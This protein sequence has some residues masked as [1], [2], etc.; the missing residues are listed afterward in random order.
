MATL[1]IPITDHNTEGVCTQQYSVSYK[2]DGASEILWTGVF[3][4]SPIVLDNLGDDES[5]EV[6][7]TRLCCNGSV[8]TPTVFVVS[9]VILVAPTGFTAVQAGAN[10]NLDSDDYTGA[11]AYE[12]QRA[13]DVDFTVNL[14]DIASVAVSNATDLAVPASTYW[15]RWRAIKG[16][17]ASE[18]AI[19]SVTVS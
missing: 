18:W 16:G 4:T 15:Y 19:D 10:V 5:Y 6:T 14:T 12:W 8:S 9:T 11:T 7:V 17:V 13:D 3:Y 2:F 1:T